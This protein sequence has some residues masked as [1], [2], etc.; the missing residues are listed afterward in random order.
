MDIHVKEEYISPIVKVIK[1]YLK[2]YKF[3]PMDEEW[4]KRVCNRFEEGKGNY[5]CAE[6]ELYLVK[7]AFSYAKSKGPQDGITPSEMNDIYTWLEEKYRNSQ[8]Q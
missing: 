5:I 4:L 3:D 6:N 2:T 8:K 1:W 7:E